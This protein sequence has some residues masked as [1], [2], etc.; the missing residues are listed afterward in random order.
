ME[1]FIRIPH[2]R[3]V[4]FLCL[5]VGWGH[6]Q[7]L[8]NLQIHGYVTQGFLFSSRNN[9][10]TMNS[11]T[12][13]LEWTDGAVSV[14]D[15]ATDH[16]RVGVQLHMY[17]LGHF[18]GPNVLVDWALAD[19]KVDDRLGFRVGKIKTIIGLFNDSQDVDSVHQWILLPQAIYPVDNRGFNLA[20]L[21]G[22][23]YGTFRV[24]EKL[25]NL[26]YSVHMG[27]AYLDA[28]GGYMQQLSEFG[29]T[30]NNTPG[31]VTYGGD[32]RWLTPLR[33]LMVGASALS[34]SLD[35]TATLGSVHLPASA[36]VAYYAQ[37]ERGR[38][39]FAGEYWRVPI[40]PEI[41]LGPDTF[42]LP[43]DERCWYAMAMYRLSDKFRVGTYYSHYV[44]QAADTSDPANYSKDW[45]VS[46]RYDF[47]AYF[48]GKIE[49]HFLHGD[50]MGYYAID[51]PNGLATNSKM[52]A[53]KL[54][55]TF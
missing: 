48:Y 55:F 28:N 36:S 52:L 21:G 19:Y 14:V 50:G 23:V 41:T 49:G 25:G 35:G 47:N 5:A 34:Q 17:Q 44:N 42:A 51:N 13:S 11:S 3:F 20:E 1:R 9:Y 24:G 22:Q 4:V 31:G 43:Y 16:L 30:F 6:A 40:H 27:Q 26:Q 45:V 10:L 53:A 33:G 29:L 8:D 38:F 15:S 37:F 32:L 54:G 2:F 7:S 46:G 39:Y 12:G 18:G